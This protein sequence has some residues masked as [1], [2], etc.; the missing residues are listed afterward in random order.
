M[1]DSFPEFVHPSSELFHF[2]GCLGDG[3]T[4][5]VVK[6]LISLG[7]ALIWEKY[8]F[9]S[10]TLGHQVEGCR[11]FDKTDFDNAEYLVCRPVDQIAEQRGDPDSNGVLDFKADTWKK[12]KPIGYAWYGG[13]YCLDT[14]YH[15]ISCLFPE[16]TKRGVRGK[17]PIVELSS[18]VILPQVM[19][20]VVD[21]ASGEVL[22]GEK[23]KGCAIQ[24][25]FM[26][27][28][29]QYD[30]KVLPSSFDVAITMETWHWP[31][32]RN[33]ARPWVIASKRFSSWCKQNRLNI[34]WV[35]VDLV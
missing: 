4:D 18:S 5:K 20:T 14:F 31:Q 19:N 8:P 29:P 34:D 3:A 7:V 28:Q 17:A 33:A 15:E 35:P 11:V 22:K 27:H 32:V 26:P 16:V 30:R 12:S 23:R 25:I 21:E 9:S 2:E 13:V 6:K 10:E 1:C 24:D